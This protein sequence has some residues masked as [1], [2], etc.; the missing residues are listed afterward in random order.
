MTARQSWF[1]D[2]IAEAYRTAEEIESASDSFSDIFN[3]AQ[4]IQNT[5]NEI[6][7]ELTKLFEEFRDF[8]RD[9]AEGKEIDK[10]KLDLFLYLLGE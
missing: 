6:D 3:D 2:K 7:I 5:L 1:F 9:L 4:Y 8:L 10:K